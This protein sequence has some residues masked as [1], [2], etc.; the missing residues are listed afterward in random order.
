LR[1][2]TKVWRRQRAPRQV[3]PT[4][5]FPRLNDIALATEIS[6]ALSEI[7]QVVGQGNRAAK[8]PSLGERLWTDAARLK[9]VIV[10]GLPAAATASGKTS[11]MQRLK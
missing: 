8:G 3:R 9:P 1:G 11:G 4:N 7:H 10:G 2:L 5:Q 6:T